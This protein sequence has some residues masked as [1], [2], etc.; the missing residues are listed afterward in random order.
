M[1]SQFISALVECWKPDIHTFHLPVGE[2]MITLEDVTIQLRL[3]IND[4]LVSGSSSFS[5]EIIEQYCEGLL[6]VRPREEDIIKSGI[7]L[8]WLDKY[9]KAEHLN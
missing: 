4:Q 2:C 5:Q 9:F 1:H 3:P 8:R 7:S 6:G